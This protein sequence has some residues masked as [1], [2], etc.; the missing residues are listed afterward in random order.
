LQIISL[1]KKLS[2]GSLA[3]HVMLHS[4][5]P[6]VADALSLRTEQK[7]GKAATEEEKAEAPPRKGLIQQ[8]IVGM[9]REAKQTKFTRA[10][11]K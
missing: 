7:M 11:L 10:V 4:N 2:T 3:N 6:A 1:G 8:S 5:I 9:S